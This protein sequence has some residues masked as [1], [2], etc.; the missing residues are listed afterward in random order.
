MDKKIDILL[1]YGIGNKLNNKEGWSKKIQEYLGDEY[2]YKESI[3][4]DVSQINEDE[5]F[6]GE[7]KA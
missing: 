1:V 4:S 5:I 3:W 7:Y 6:S 2:H